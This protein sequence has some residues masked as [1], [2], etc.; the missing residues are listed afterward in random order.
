MKIF[1]SLVLSLAACIAGAAEVR[2]MSSNAMREV[3]LEAAP[4]FEKA[5]GHKLALTFLGSVDILRRLRAGEGTATWSCCRSV[6]STS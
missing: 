4:Q 1:L 2:V 5:S 3:L 6:R